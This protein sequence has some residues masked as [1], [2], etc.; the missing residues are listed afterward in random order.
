[1]AVHLLLLSA[2]KVQPNLKGEV[3]IYSDCLGALHRVAELPPYRI[4]S[5]CKHSDI[6]K[7]ILVNCGGLTF[8]RTYLHVDAHQDKEKEWDEMTRQAQLNTICDAG[9]KGEVYNV[10]EVKEL[11][12]RTFPLEPICVFVNGTKMTTDTGP[13]IRYAAQRVMAKKFFHDYGI[14]FG[15]EFEE[16]SWEMVYETLEN[17]V[18]RLFALWACKQ[19]M[20][21]AATNDFLAM[22]D[23]TGQRSKMCPC[24]N[25]CAETAEHVLYCQEEGR[26]DFLLKS[27]DILDN[28]LDE[29]DTDWDLADCVVS[30]VKGRGARTM[31]DICSPLGARYRKLARSQDKIG[32]RRFMDGMIS[33]EIVSLQD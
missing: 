33:K 3:K 15:A 19:V 9:A 8:S 23:K 17:K 31:S 27:T 30:Y 2:N 21:V 13:E 16:V 10:K 26:V 6:L 4:P 24:C 22:Q 1:M 25:V 11:S 12:S 20:G 7:N 28:W 5:R 18:P 14:L 29:N 32:W